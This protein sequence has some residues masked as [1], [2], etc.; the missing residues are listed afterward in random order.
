MRRYNIVM[1]KPRDEQTVATLQFDPS[2]KEF[3]AY[4][5]A[6]LRFVSCHIGDLS[7]ELQSVYPRIE[8]Q[9]KRI[10]NKY[11]HNES[12]PILRVAH[13]AQYTIFLY[14]LARSAFENGTRQIADK[15]YSLLRIASS[16]D[17][18]Y[19][20]ALPEVWSCDHP[21][22]AVIGRGLFGRDAT[23]FFSQN[24]NIGNNRGVYPKINGNLHMYSGSSLLGETQAYGNVVLSNGACAIDAGELRDCVVFGRSPGLVIK[25][26]A[27]EQFIRL[28][29]LA[30]SA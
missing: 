20:V 5:D 4:L 21:L 1:S 26:L 25:P 6:Q 24:C 18:Y 28:S 23:L 16:A 27:H 13:N 19:E 15:I 7:A 11:F 9:F 17:L 29:P 30:L 2:Q 10:R 12:G 14:Q 22:G 8:R 3:E